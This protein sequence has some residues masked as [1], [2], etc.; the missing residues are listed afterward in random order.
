MLRD[1]PARMTETEAE[2]LAVRALAFIAGEPEELGQ[3]LALTGIGP[4]SIRAAAGEPAFLVGV[5]EYM[6]SNEPL[7]IAFAAREAIRPT[8]IA[9]ARHVLDATL[10]FEG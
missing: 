2:T 7:L 4:E 3:F 5:L 10:P 1:R 6:L 8:M 9:A